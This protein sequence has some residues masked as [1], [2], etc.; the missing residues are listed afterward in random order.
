[1]NKKKS[2]LTAFLLAPV[3]LYAQADIMPAGMKSIADGILAIFTGP[4]VK[5]LLAIFLC[6]A[7]VAYGF[8]KDNEK[9]KRNCIAVGVACGILVV[10]SSVVEA[11]MGAAG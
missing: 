1:M 3:L 7:A 2:L 6:G 10:A 8:N 4:F 11:V 5:A 9:V